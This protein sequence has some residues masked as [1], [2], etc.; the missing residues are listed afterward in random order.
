[1]SEIRPLSVE[2]LDAYV[3]IVANAYPGIELSTPEAREQFKE[4]SALFLREDAYRHFTGLFRQGR[5][6]G[7]MICYDLT[8]NML[9]TR[10]PAGGVGMVAV[11]LPYKKEHVAKEMI[12][13]YLRYYRRQGAPLALLYPFRPDFYKQMGFG[14]GTKVNQYRLRPAALPKGPSKAHVHYMAADD[15]QAL[16]DCYARFVARHHGMIGRPANAFPRILARLPN[17]IVGYE[18]DGQVEGYLI[19]SFEKGESFIVNDMHLGELVYENH[20]ALSELLTF[21]HTQADQVRHIVLETQDE[22]FH[23]LLLDPRSKPG[24]LIPIVNHETNVQGLGLMYRV[25]DIPGILGA[26]ANRDWNG[27]S[28]RLRLTVVDSFL[29]ENA[30]HYLL[31]FVDGQLH[32]EESGPHDV[33]VD[34]DISEFSSLLV[35]TVD[36]SSLYRYGLARISDEGYVKAVERALAVESKPICMTQF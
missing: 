26:L 23:F 22:S 27:Q 1:M 2:E 10:L 18:V 24:T 25:L 36:F 29:P 21:L 28:L 4:R 20:A 11:D 8:M 7:V 9:G 31:C 33:A 16:A 32:L 3:A 12:L 15:Q 14:Y 6:A 30:G 19:F 5:M 34:M 17:R 13:H 35:G